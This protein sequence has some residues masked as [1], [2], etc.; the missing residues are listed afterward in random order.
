MIEINYSAQS[1]YYDKKVPVNRKIFIILDKLSITVPKVMA[2]LKRTILIGLSLQDK[3]DENLLG[4][5]DLVIDLT[6][7]WILRCLF[8]PICICVSPCGQ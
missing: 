2:V 5:T 6:R 7:T 4:L 8:S 3:T 1:V